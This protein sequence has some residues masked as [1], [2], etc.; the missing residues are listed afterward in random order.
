M[1]SNLLSRLMVHG[2]LFWGIAPK[3]TKEIRLT[4]SSGAEV[5]HQ[6]CLTSDL[7]ATCPELATGGKS[8]KTT[9]LSIH[10]D[11]GISHT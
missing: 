11:S 9:T 7:G 2:P 3:D 4:V 5:T 1:E 10:I 8:L 6:T